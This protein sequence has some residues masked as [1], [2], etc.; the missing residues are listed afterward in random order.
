MREDLRAARRDWRVACEAVRAE[1]VSLFG[2]CARFRALLA[3]VF[4]LR[5]G[6]WR[7]ARKAFV[8]CGWGFMGGASGYLGGAGGLDGGT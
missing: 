5:V 4:G 6:C 7:L 8:A 3:T 1:R 2:A